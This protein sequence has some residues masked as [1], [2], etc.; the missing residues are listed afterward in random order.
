MYKFMGKIIGKAIYEDI[1]IEP[2][3]SRAFLNLVLDEKNDFEELKYVDLTLYKNLLKL[4]HSKEN[5]EN[6][7]LSFAIDENVMGV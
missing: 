7:G 2:V 3:F 6:Y 4:K 5:I 1:L